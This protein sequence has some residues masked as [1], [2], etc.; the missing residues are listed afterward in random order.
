MNKGVIKRLLPYLLRNKALLALTLLCALISGLCGLF[1]PIVTGRGIDQ[2]T[3]EGLRFMPRTILLLGGLILAAV[4]T[5][6]EYSSLAAVLAGRVAQ[7]L[8]EECFDAL[9]ALPLKYYDSTAR[10]DVISRFTN[11]AEAVAE[12]TLQA[13]NQVLS[14]LITVIG[15]LIFI[16]II[17]PLA[18]VL[19]LIISP[20]Y[21]IFSR[22]IASRSAGM[23]K[24]QQDTL[25]RLNGYA[26]ERISAMRLV[27]AFSN[28]R[29]TNE[30]FGAIN[31]ELYGYGFKAQFYSAVTNPSTRMIVNISY[32]TV[33]A[34]GTLLALKSGSF[35]VGAI[36]SL[37]IYANQYSKPINELTGLITQMQTA[38]AAAARVFGLMDEKREAVQAPT[39]ELSSAQGE[40]EFK[41]V[42]FSYQPQSPLIKC[43]SL[44]VEKGSTVAIIGP[45]GAGKTTLVNLLMRFYDID[46]GQILI[47]GIDIMSL[48]REKLR[49]QF[50]MVLQETWLFT[51]TVA[52][53]IAFS[54]PQ[55]ARDE[56][57]A[58]A[59]AAHAH[60]FIEAMPKGYDTVIFGEGEGLS[61]GQKQLLTIARAMLAQAP[62]LILDEATGSV[63]TKTELRIQRAFKKLMAGKTSFIIAHRLSTIREAD[64][65]LFIKEGNIVE[66]G[67]HEEL[68]AKGGEY[69]LLEARY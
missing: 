46:S 20:F 36:S 21:Y 48:S 23:F 26:E 42:S 65:I 49:R 18:G 22:L 68:L 9:Q 13:V 47:D 1:I 24:K 8:R 67:T 3:A 64:V 61:Q 25:G 29:Q 31:E 5:Q 11:D 6:W 60:R 58:A 14:G 17:S 57:I 12:G 51:G 38:I 37:I 52:E 62:I 15:S 7:A 35:T 63:D 33:G 10:G 45:T 55:A 53:N 27:R 16:F 69:A 34:V 39:A 54:K 4:L 59:K 19:I 2:M 28:E 30:E 41:D 44:K 40:V 32:I 56:I 43:F 66:Q 50:S